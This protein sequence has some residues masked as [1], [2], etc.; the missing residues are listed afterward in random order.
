MVDFPLV[1]YNEDEDRYQAVHHPFTSA[2]DADWDRLES[3]PA[4]VLAK[5]YDVIRP[6]AGAGWRSIPIHRADLGSPLQGDWHVCRRDRGQF[7]HLI[8]AFQYGAP[9]HGGIALGIDRVPWRSSP[10]ASASAKGDC[11]PQNGGRH[12]PDDGVASGV[13]QAQ[14]DELHIARRKPPR[15]LSTHS[16]RSKRGFHVGSLASDDP[17]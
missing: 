5:A 8:E 3:D 14:L 17:P 6:T 7:G 4:S 1:E 15:P 2:L 16:R 13:T 12:R 9:P 11:L 10:R